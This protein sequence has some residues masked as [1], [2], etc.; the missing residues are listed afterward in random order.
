MH[1]TPMVDWQQVCLNLRRHKPLS[2]IAKDVGSD[3]QHLNRLA[4]GDVKQP[5]FDTG[6]ALLDLHFDLFPG[7]HDSSLLRVGA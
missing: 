4:R 5:R 6:M 7:Q 1:D 3:W 2:Q